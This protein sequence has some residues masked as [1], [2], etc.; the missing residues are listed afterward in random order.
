MGFSASQLLGI[1]AG[2]I[3]C[4]VFA[5]GLALIVRLLVPR[6]RLRRALF[7][8]AVP[9]PFA[10]ATLGPFAV[11]PNVGLAAWLEAWSLGDVIGIAIMAA[12][13]WVAAWLI[14]RS[15]Q[16]SVVDPDIFG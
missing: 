13:S 14:L 7:L 4:V 16:R 5:V 8:S 15:S 2:V 9:A 1:G 10:S 3:I 11:M 6:M 12:A